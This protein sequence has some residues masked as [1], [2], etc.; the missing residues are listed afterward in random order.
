MKKISNRCISSHE[1]R[2]TGYLIVRQLI[3][4]FHAL[5]PL[6]GLQK[7]DVGY[8]TMRLI[9]SI[10]PSILELK[11]R[12]ITIHLDVVVDMAALLVD[13]ACDPTH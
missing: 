3:V 1:S 10:A 13:H 7:T 9:P 6:R 8:G 5:V 11:L 2:T 12:S 4:A